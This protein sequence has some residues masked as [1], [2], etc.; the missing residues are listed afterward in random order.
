[1]ATVTQL[2]TE[3]AANPL[4]ELLALSRRARLAASTQELAFIAVNDTHALRPYRQAAL[5]FANGGLKAL[6]GVVEPEAN[7]PYAQWLNRVC[8]TLHDAHAEAATVSA[9]QLPAELAGEWAEWL[10]PYALW[11]P[12]TGGPDASQAGG[13]LL[14]AQGPWTAEAM[15]LLN[16]WM[17]VWQHAWLAQ[18]R[19][20]AW[21]WPTLRRAIGG[22][23]P[24]AP[25][26]RNRWTL[27]T[28]LLVAAMFV[29]VRLSV[30]APGELVPAHPV[31]IRA[32]VDGVV[33]QF[34]VQPN[35]AVKTGQLLL[36][37][38]EASVAAKHEVATQML[39]AAQAEYR[40]SAQQ[41]VFDA[42][43][44]AQLA[45]LLG[46]VEERRAEAEY[47]KGQFERSRVTAPQDGVAL[48][49]D[50]SEWIGK[51]VQTG[52]RIM[53][54]AVPG[55]VE[56]EAW[57]PIGDA[58][59]LPADATAKLFLAADPLA[60]LSARVRYVA[61]EAVPRPDGTYAYRL[62]AQ[63][64]EPTQQRVG[65]KGTVQLSGERVPLIYWMLRRPLAAMRQMLAL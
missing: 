55:D 60:A 17:Q 22:L 36:T 56:L 63:L 45:A 53:R 18:S 8:R 49:D 7:A 39:A 29:P 19:A 50:P 27:L 35:E 48:F 61:H 15:A 41:A 31:L 12:F 9:V 11:L 4:A 65:L 26:W 23:R 21:S 40:Q 42:R 54:I 2:K 43:S 5:W 25:W 1:M 57:L 59:P 38:D 14:A 34:H 24:A 30:L 10:P 20:G 52:E 44:K 6:S 16:E 28:A 62:R 47:H 32:S 51:P 13:L 33:G 3:P 46:K 64:L 58:I 37:F